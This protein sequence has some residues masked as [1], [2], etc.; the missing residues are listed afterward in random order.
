MNVLFSEEAR[1]VIVE[2]EKF[3][4]EKKPPGSGKRFTTKFKQ[5]ILNYSN[6]QVHLSCKFPLFRRR[7][8]FCFILN[9]WTVAYEVQSNSFI[10]H[11]II[12]GSLLNY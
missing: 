4:E 3:V 9:D 1:L 6:A 5:H 11:T 7:N 12:H 8:L 10:V 2:L